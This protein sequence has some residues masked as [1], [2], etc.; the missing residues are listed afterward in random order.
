MSAIIE[1]NA[2]NSIKY[3]GTKVKAAFIPFAL[4]NVLPD[5]LNY[6]M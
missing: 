4:A 1:P 2:I 5:W 3:R 6:F